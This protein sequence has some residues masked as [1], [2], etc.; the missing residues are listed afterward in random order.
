MSCK[1]INGLKVYISIVFRIY[2]KLKL[3]TCKEPRYFYNILEIF[4]RSWHD[5]QE[6]V[7]VKI[8]FQPFSR[9]MTN[10]KKDMDVNDKILSH[11]LNKESNVF[12]HGYQ[13]YNSILVREI[14][15]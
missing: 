10:H 8:G 14:K 2:G 13:Y 12:W 1:N 5:H 15:S 11:L 9:I 6:Y 4:N 3:V 7:W